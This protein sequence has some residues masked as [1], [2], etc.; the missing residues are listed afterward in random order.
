MERMLN[1]TLKAIEGEQGNK[2]LTWQDIL[3]LLNM[4]NCHF[5]DY[6]EEHECFTYLTGL[7]S[8]RGESWVKENASS[9][10]TR[11]ELMKED[12]RQQAKDR[13][14]ARKQLKRKRSLIERILRGK[15]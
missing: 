10:L 4:T 1:D 2:D 13:Y 3:P 12:K 5:K 6:D 8:E 9:I 11:W 14:K 15:A 7:I